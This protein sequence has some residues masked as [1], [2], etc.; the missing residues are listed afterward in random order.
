M[1]SLQFILPSLLFTILILSP[2]VYSSPEI[3][4]VGE[5]SFF[6]RQEQPT[7]LPPT[8]DPNIATMTEPT[9]SIID[10]SEPETILISK[11]TGVNYSRLKNLLAAK[12]WK[13]ADQETKDR[14]LQAAGR[15]KK[16][17]LREKDINEFSCEDLRIMDRLWLDASQGKFGF[18]VQKEIW[19]HNGNPTV[20]SPKE[21]WRQFYID[22]GWKTEDSS[23][24][25]GRGH[26]NY[27]HLEG[28]SN[29]VTSK[30]GN[31]PAIWQSGN[32]PTN[33]GLFFSNSKTYY[34]LA[35]RTKTCNI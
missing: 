20:D 8:T 25:S 14:M 3:T 12:M 15:E 10:S 19:Q 13:R 6:P 32:I 9:P 21:V 23:T 18:S 17:W 27:D 34:F 29:I 4:L 26:V 33:I 5:F 28:F 16:G 24:E 11:A 22:I 35:L 30:S 31:L 1:S 2:L 7:P